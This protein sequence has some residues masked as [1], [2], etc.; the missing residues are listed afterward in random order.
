MNERGERTVPR[1]AAGHPLNGARTKE[2]LPATLL[3][4]LLVPASW[5]APPQDGPKRALQDYLKNVGQL[6]RDA[7]AMAR[8]PGLFA[9]HDEDRS[10]RLDG[11]ELLQLL[12][13]ALSQQAGGPPPGP[14]WVVLM[15]DHLL[16][17]Q[18][19]NR[20]GLLEPLELFLAPALGQLPGPPAAAPG[21]GEEDGPSPEPE[22]G[23][24]G[25]GPPAPLAPQ[26]TA[27]A[28]RTVQEPGMAGGPSL[29][30]PAQKQEQRPGQE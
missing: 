2:A 4:L 26:D 11:L 7:G 10:G 25:D 30:P 6:G 14:D 24:A 18:D 19:W 29:Q 21:G 27:G 20:D 9:L 12:S 16:E 8:E 5:A 15:V 13:E 22:A 17:T 23:R 3:L 28:P 1:Q